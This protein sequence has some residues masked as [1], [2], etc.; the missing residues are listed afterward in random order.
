VETSGGGSVLHLQALGGGIGRGAVNAPM[1]EGTGE[2]KRGGSSSSLRIGWRRSQIPV[3]LV[4]ILEPNVDNN[5]NNNDSDN[6]DKGTVSSLAGKSVPNSAE[7][8][9]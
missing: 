7:F 4:N 9:N 8:Y 2:G 5:D 1:E 6:N 3:P